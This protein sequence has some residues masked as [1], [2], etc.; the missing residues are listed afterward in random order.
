MKGLTAWLTEEKDAFHLGVVQS[1]K[2]G[3]ADD[4]RHDRIDDLNQSFT[5]AI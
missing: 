5:A 1:N 3:R 4:S 2:D